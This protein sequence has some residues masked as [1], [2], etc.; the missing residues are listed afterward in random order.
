MHPR[1]LAAIQL[2]VLGVPVIPI[3]APYPH[4]HAVNAHG[5]CTICAGFKVPV[6][7]WQAERSKDIEQ[8]NRWW[9]VEAYNLAIVP[10][11]VGMT[12]IDLDGAAGAA[13]WAKLCSDLS[14]DPGDPPMVRTPGG[15]LHLYYSG[16]TFRPS[17]GV[18]GMGIDVRSEDSYVLV[19]PSEIDGREYHWL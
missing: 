10:A 17:A 16:P 2:A 1:H 13:G 14:M 5:K 11:D 3:C 18:L 15:G 12:V 9:A 8:I 19:P 7:K 4:E 6:I